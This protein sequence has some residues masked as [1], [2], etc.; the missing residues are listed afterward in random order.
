MADKTIRR[1]LRNNPGGAGKH[2]ANIP[3]NASTDQAEARAAGAA[4]AAGLG[5]S[6]GRTNWIDDR[7]DAV[8]QAQ[9]FA[10]GISIG[11]AER[12]APLVSRT[13]R[14]LDALG[15]HERSRISQ[16]LDHALFDRVDDYGG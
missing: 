16:T 9:T 4:N 14:R 15:L 5:A 3:V 1:V 2:W 10:A 11:M 8:E 12:L 6:D 13:R 7:A